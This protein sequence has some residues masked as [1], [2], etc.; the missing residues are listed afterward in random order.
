[1]SSPRRWYWW[2]WAQIVPR[3]RISSSESFE[4]VVKAMK[5]MLYV[6]LFVGILVSAICSQ[7]SLLLLTSSL[8]KVM[9]FSTVKF[10]VVL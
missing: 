8:V 1:M 10:T 5:A 7:G 6:F 2:D 9:S 3:D 4:G